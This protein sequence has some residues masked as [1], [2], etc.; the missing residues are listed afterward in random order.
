MKYLS[1]YE[2]FSLS[3]TEKENYYIELKK[4]LNTNSPPE[5]LG[6]LKS[7]FSAISGYADSDEI[8]KKLEIYV[9]KQIPDSGIKKKV[10]IAS[11]C[12]L[13]AFLVIIPISV[14]KSNASAQ[15]DEIYLEALEMYQKGRYPEA[16]ELFN[17]IKNYKESALYIV[18]IN[19]YMSSPFINGYIATAGRSVSFGSAE[20]DGDM[21]NGAEPIE[22]IVL[23]SDID[24]KRALLISKDILA[25]DIFGDAGSSWKDCNIRSWLN[26][27]FFDASFSDSEKEQIVTTLYSEALNQDS[28]IPAAETLD[29]I[30]L[31]SLQ[32]FETYS[33]IPFSSASITDALEDLA[34]ENTDSI[35]R[36]EWWLRTVDNTGYVYRISR[37]GMVLNSE[38]SSPDTC[39]IRPIIWVKFN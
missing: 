8:S 18:A 22:W 25:Y 5:N 21:T 1:S 7:A 24:N 9:R 36:I 13:L 4:Q 17:E 38:D 6:E 28:D 16:L 29:K 31:L 35:G 27:S 34:G 3:D 14:I 2:F 10:L 26:G 37:S 33:D 19:S 12:I 23:Q 11:I 20:Q 30:S 32:E 15:K 39:G